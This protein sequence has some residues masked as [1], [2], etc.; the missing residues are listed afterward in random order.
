MLSQ[1][2]AIVVGLLVNSK[3][4]VGCLETKKGG[5]DTKAASAG[6]HS[7]LVTLTFGN[8]LKL[9]FISVQR[10][11]TLNCDGGTGIARGTER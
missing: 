8:S 9:S 2:E 7:K 11:L 5:N 4:S 1:N 6:V 3:Y 10:Y